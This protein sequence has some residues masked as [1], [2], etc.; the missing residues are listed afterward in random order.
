VPFVQNA[1]Q[2]DKRAAF[3]AQTFAGTMFVIT[4]GRLVHR[5]PGKSLQAGAA[6]HLSVRAL[7]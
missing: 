2:W 1:G 4:D 5:L 7:E 6:R 3:A